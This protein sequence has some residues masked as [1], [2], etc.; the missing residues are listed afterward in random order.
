MDHSETHVAGPHGTILPMEIPRWT[1]GRMQN[2]VRGFLHGVAAIAAVIGTV[3]LAWTAPGWGIRI[4][5]IVFGIAM[6]ALYTTSSLYHGIPWNGT[7]KKRMQRLDHSMILVLIAGTYTP[8]TIAALDGWAQWIVLGVAWGTVAVGAAQHTWF[9][10][11][12]QTFSMA[13][14]VTMGWLGILIAWEFVIELGW[15]AALL[16]LLG[17][18]IYTIGMIILITNWPRLWPRV[19]SYHELF[20]VMV[21]AGTVVHFI[22]VWRYVLPKA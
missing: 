13:L 8:P 21:I 16:G 4:G 2:P 15:A 12:K 1:L 3:F 5:V 6:V 18:A 7:W 9:P 11:E 10:R 22:M 20:H 14:G 17:G 19:C